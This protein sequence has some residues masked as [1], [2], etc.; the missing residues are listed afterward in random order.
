[1]AQRRADELQAE[2][3]VEAER[4]RVA[5]REAEPIRSRLRRKKGQL[6]ELRQACARMGITVVIEPPSKGGPSGSHS[7][8]GPTAG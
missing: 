2:C 3:A 1:M 5:R 6:E 8:D 7:A 4:Y